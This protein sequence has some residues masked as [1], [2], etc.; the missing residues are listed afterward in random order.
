MAHPFVYFIVHGPPPSEWKRWP[1]GP[2]MRYS[3][4]CC[5]A[6]VTVC[7]V[8]RFPTLRQRARLCTT[9]TAPPATTPTQVSATGTEKRRREGG[10]GL[11]WS[12]VVGWFNL[13]VSW[14]ETAV[15][16]WERRATIRPFVRTSPSS[17][18]EAWS[19]VGAVSL[20]S[21]SRRAS[22]WER[23]GQTIKYVKECNQAVKVV[24]VQFSLLVDFG[25]VYEHVV[26]TWWEGI[27]CTDGHMNEY[28]HASRHTPLSCNSP[29]HSLLSPADPVHM[30]SALLCAVSSKRCCCGLQCPVCCCHGDPVPLVLLHTSA[31][32]GWHSE[33]CLHLQDGLYPSLCQPQLTKCQ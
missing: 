2:F 7:G 29:I 15:P 23:Q 19:E 3:C 10:S 13:L 5:S 30:L 32:S 6:C 17:S 20:G 33:G 9:G 26:A 21:G 25:L 8:P 22:G 24:S 12:S 18:C 16:V 1:A 4:C 14:D 11:C 27:P 31:V 28:T